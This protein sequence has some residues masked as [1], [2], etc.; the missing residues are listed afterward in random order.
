MPASDSARLE[1]YKAI[2]RLSSDQT[3][4]EKVGHHRTVPA[5]LSAERRVAEYLRWATAYLM[6]RDLDRYGDL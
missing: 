1:A 3:M 2:L 5:N 6:H 4:V